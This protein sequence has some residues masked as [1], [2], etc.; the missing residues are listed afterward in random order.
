MLFAADLHYTLKQLDWLVA[1][2]ERYDL[3]IIGGDLLDLVRRSISTYKSLL[4]KSICAESDG[5]HPCLSVP[6]TTMA[7]AG[8]RL[9][10]L[11]LNGSCK[12]EQT[13]CMLMA[14]AQSLA[15]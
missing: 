9:T 10:N 15:I 11:W 5:I 14:K 13:A 1:N 12:A 6:E 8:M 2:A 3:V 4:S 7:I